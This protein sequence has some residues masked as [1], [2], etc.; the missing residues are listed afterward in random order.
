MV[1]CALLAGRFWLNDPTRTL[2]TI[3]VVLLAATAL[4]VAVLLRRPEPAAAWLLVVASGLSAAMAAVSVVATYGLR[5]DVRVA[6]L[7]PLLFGVCDLFALGLAFALLGRWRRRLRGS[8]DWADALDAAMAA[9]GAYLLIWVL[10][11]GPELAESMSANIAVIATA[12]PLGAL[13]VL[14]S[15]IMFAFTG[16]VRTWSGRLLALSGIAGVGLALYSSFPVGSPSV[17]IGAAFVLVY[18]IHAILLGGAGVANDM[19]TVGASLRPISDRMP[20]W[21]LVLFALLAFLA[22]VNL[23]NEFAQGG[24][25]PPGA[26]TV[27]VPVWCAAAIFLLLVVRLALVANVARDRAARLTRAMAEQRELEQQISYRAMHDPLT[28][29]SNRD[30]LAEW[31]ERAHTDQGRAGWRT[32]NGQ[33]LVM[34]DLDGFKDFND[35]LGP[36]VGDQ[37]LIQVAQRL[38]AAAP[39]DAVAA[40]LDGDDFAVLLLD[41]TPTQARA[42]ASQLLDALR[43]PYL[44]GKRELFLSTSL[45]LLTTEPDRRPPTASVALRDADLALHA[46]KQSGRNR[47]VEFE[48]HLRSDRLDYARI[49]TGLRQAVANHELALDYQPIVDLRSRAIVGVEALVRWRPG[50]GQRLVSPAEFI[51]VAEQTGLIVE[52]GTWVLRQACR[53]ARR[54]HAE[55]GIWLSVNVSG[56]QLDEPSI[57]DVVLAALAEAELPGQALVLELTESSLIATAEDERELAE[58]NRLRE[59]GI[60]V[61]I[62]DF[63]TGYSSLSTVSRLPADIV[64]I[65]SSFIRDPADREVSRR[66]WNFVRAI[67]QVISS[68]NLQAVAE[69]VETQAQADVLSRL[70]CQMGQGYLFS[71]PVTADRINALL[72]D[73]PTVP[74]ADRT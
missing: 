70:R 3:L 10:Y 11:T 29:L 47:V 38:S 21:R 65:D 19:V 9:I 55:S 50:G 24:P 51:P 68:L 15:A 74:L 54:W 53:D 61:A 42:W 27:L 67:L 32:G 52:I 2:T 40:R 20:R 71:R 56:R 48:L 57:G 28:G 26:V 35:I 41:T 25:D 6:T 73:A 64:K 58:L 12:I 33:A 62:D 4:A 17:D 44:V 49:A 63:G 5:L 7:L 18:L 72:S 59:H 69:G 31:L 37:L 16:G 66:H 8:V 13:L 43:K 30:V 23:A 39:P 45:G 14:T 36:Q 1:Q 34:V 22:P 60:R 46:A